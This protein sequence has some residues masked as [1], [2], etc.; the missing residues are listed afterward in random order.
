MTTAVAGLKIPAHIAIIMD[1]NGRWAKEQGL[2]RI[3]GHESGA[4]TVREITRECSRLG[5]G[6]L[7]LYAFSAENWKRPLREVDFLMKLLEQYLVQERKEI[8]ENNI[9]F[10]SIGRLDELPEG[11]R[12]QLQETSDLSAKNTGMVLSLAL[13]YGG[14]KEIVDAV[15]RLAQEVKEGKRL[16]EDIDEQ[17]IAGYLYDPAAPDPDLLIRTGGDLRVSNFLLWQISYTELWVTP[18]RWPDFKKEHLYEAIREFSKRDRR[19]GNINDQA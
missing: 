7:T 8:M 17:A 13:A 5:V 11:V 15:R 18:V 10:T 3:L 6:R 1:G 9:R 16:P 2:Q 19:F 4:E 14:R 12:R